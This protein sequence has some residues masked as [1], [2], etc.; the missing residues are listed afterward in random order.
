MIFIIYY[1]STAESKKQTLVAKICSIFLLTNICSRLIIEN[2]EQMFARINV[3][4]N[5]YLYTI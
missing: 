4:F 2:M 5:V 3:R 1:S